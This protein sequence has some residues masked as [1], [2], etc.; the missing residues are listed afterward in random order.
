VAEQIAED[1]FTAPVAEFLDRVLPADR[2]RAV[3]AAGGWDENLHAELRELGWAELTAAPGDGGLGVPLCRL[4]TLVRLVGERLVPGPLV[5]QLVLPALLPGGLSGVRLA[6]L[7]DPA[8]TLHWAPELGRIRLSG[9]TVT[10]TVELVRFGAQADLLVLAVD[11]AHGETAVVVL[12]A[13]DPA[14]RIE[15]L[16][17]SDPAARYARVEVIDRSVLPGEVLVTGTAAAELLVR[18]RAWMRILTACELAGIAR[19]VLADSVAY[20][21]QR[22]QFGRPIGSFQAL[23]HILATMAQ[24]SLSLDALSE[25]AA[26]DAGTQEG[27]ELELTALTVKA[28]A[29][30]SAR[31]VC[32]DGLQVHGGI[33]FTTEHDLHWFLRRALALRTWYGDERE[34]GGLI[35]ARRLAGAA[36]AR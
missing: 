4:A 23:K 33:G 22:E 29:A 24:L 3:L 5:E 36:R 19:R 28:W 34:L 1:D 26:S 17:G 35:G 11:D 7:V 30:Q 2:H 20:A 27:P 8:V 12:P 6:V 21:K 32:E 10:G 14:V 16:A 18:I 13:A 25:A 31:Q 9:D 15:E